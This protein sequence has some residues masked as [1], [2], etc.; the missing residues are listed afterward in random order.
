MIDTVKTVLA[1][2]IGI[3]R[4]ADHERQ[5]LNAVHVIV[6]GVLLAAL[7]VLTLVTVVRIV[8]G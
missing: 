8:A 1:G 4:K 3:R 7:F 5:P 6:A 2:M